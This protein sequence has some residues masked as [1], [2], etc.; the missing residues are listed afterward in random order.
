MRED[1]MVDF[2]DEG[3]MHYPKIEQLIYDVLYADFGVEPD[4][5]WRQSCVDG[6]L[7]VAFY[8][9]KPV[10]T[11]ALIGQPGSDR[12]QLRQLAVLPEHRGT[13]VGRALVEELEA[14]ARAQGT[15]EIWLNARE[16]AF[17]FYE[18]LGY[19]YTGDVFVSELTH[20]PHRPM[21]KLLR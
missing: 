18:A 4:G 15:T 14:S 1:Y 3:W 8:G 9:M 10:G 20:L 16:V 5:E 19:E 2:V 7:V 21:R 13:G 6:E 12:L 11:A 17:G